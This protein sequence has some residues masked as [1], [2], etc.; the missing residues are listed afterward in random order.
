MSKHKSKWSYSEYK[1]GWSALQRTKSEI[2]KGVFF[3]A[4]KKTEDFVCTVKVYPK[5][6]DEKCFFVCA[7]FIDCQL[8]TKPSKAFYKQPAS[9]ILLPDFIEKSCSFAIEMGNMIFKSF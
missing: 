6:I 1:N 7:C 3:K 5:Q 8:D 4:C 2:K 9:E